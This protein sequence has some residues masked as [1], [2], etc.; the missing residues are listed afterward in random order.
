MVAGGDGYTCILFNSGNVKCVGEN[1]SG[2]LG[3]GTLVDRTTWVDTLGVSQAKAITAGGD[4]NCVLNT[5]DTIQCWGG[6]WGGQLANGDFAD[7]PNAVVAQKLNEDNPINLIWTSWSGSQLGGELFSP[8]PV[9]AY[10]DRDGNS[11]D[12][13]DTLSIALYTERSCT[14]PAPALQGTTSVTM[15]NG[16]A[17][18]SGIKSD[19]VGGFYVKTTS[20]AGG[21][22]HCDYVGLAGPGLQFTQY[23]TEAF[24]NQ[25]FAVLPKLKLMKADWSGVLTTPAYNVTLAAFS[26][27]TC[28][29]AATGVLS[30]DVNPATTSGG[31]VSF[32]NVR[33]SQAGDIFIKASAPGVS[34]TCFSMKIL[35]AP[36]SPYKLVI[37]RNPA[38]GV[39]GS[40]LVSD[41]QVS[42]RDSAG[43][44]MTSATHSITLSAYTDSQCTNAASGTLTA[45]SNPV[46]AVGGK[47]VFNSISYPQIGTIYVKATTGGLVA[48]CAGP[49]EVGGPIG[50]VSSIAWSN[51]YGTAYAGISAQNAPAVLLRDGL[52][53]TVTSATN[54]V[55][56][57]AYSD[58]CNTPVAP[59]SF[60][61][62]SPTT[63]AINGAAVFTGVKF[64]NPGYYGVRAEIGGIKS[65]CGWI[66]VKAGCD[67]TASVFA[68]GNG[69][70]SNPYLIST[71]SQLNQV[72]NYLN[73]NYRL[74]NSINLSGVSFAPIGSSASPFEGAFDGNSKQIQNWSYTD[75][76]TTS[77]VG[78]FGYLNWGSA[79]KNLA[80]T[81]ASVSAT[82]GEG[83]ILAGYNLGAVDNCQAAGT[84]NAKYSGGLV[85]RN[86]GLIRSSSSTATVTGMWV[87]GLCS[88][89]HGYVES[90]TA[91]GSV[92]STGGHA[93]GLAY[94]HTGGHIRNSSATGAVA[95]TGG[96]AGGLV[97]ESYG[98]VSASYATGTVNASTG[99]GLIGSSQSGTTQ[100]SYATG[101]VTAA[102]NNSAGFVGSV[103]N[104]KLFNNYATG[105]V[106]A[107]KQ[108]FSATLGGTSPVSTSNFWDTT[109]TGTTQSGS[110]T[111]KSTAQM[112]TQSTFTGWDFSNIWQISAGYPT[113]R[114]GAKNPP[115]LW[116]S[117]GSARAGRTTPFSL[118]LYSPDGLPVRASIVSGPTSGQLSA[119]TQDNVVYYT[120]QTGYAGG[121]DSFTFRAYDSSGQ[122]SLYDETF[123]IVILPDCDPGVSGFDGG[124]GQ[125]TDPYLIS[126]ITQLQQIRNNVACY[127][128]LTAN[129]DLS[130]VTFAPIGSDTVPFSGGLDGNNKTISNW[131]YSAAVDRVGFFAAT[132]YQSKV[133]N[134]VMTNVSVSGNAFVGA[135]VG[136]G[137]GD[138]SNIQVS[139]TVSGQ[140]YTGGIGGNLESNTLSNLRFS[141]TV[142]GT[143]SYVGGIA[144]ILQANSAERF[145]SSANVTGPSYVGGIAGL[146]YRG[147]SDCAS[148]G[149]VTA[150]SGTAGGAFGVISGSSGYTITRCFASGAVSGSTSGGLVG[151][152]SG[153][154]QTITDSFWD[155]QSTGKANTAGSGATGKTTAELKTQSTYTNWDFTT[156][157]SIS[158]GQYPT[159]R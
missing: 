49:I 105:S 97:G 87:G 130:G 159:L 101:A 60:H 94:Q 96:Y 3:D 53:N 89:Q 8:Q 13:A 115:T 63:N 62:D 92:T 125:L 86:Q 154:Q 11:V 76:A 23:P 30:M 116:A 142:T 98:L 17:T 80:F 145:Q 2:D 52:Q 29:T 25:A 64:D 108:G 38:L 18:F 139:G 78:F 65:I 104:S 44:L 146:N 67:P 110:G 81:G 58:F 99:G 111:G 109:T 155:T 31:Y 138:L 19:E 77:Q 16:V 151:S 34:S 33:Y 106:G 157:W 14:T 1:G 133:Q 136:F 90:S 51:F 12:I 88:L 126:T 117:S 112:Q 73:C 9:L 10:L 61:A 148:T 149:S 24:V 129:L 66:H 120:P 26:D 93:G 103:W 20:S 121:T 21:P 102:S 48:G 150:T 69:S 47:A 107:T 42:V 46:N 153:S 40:S 134:L 6:N 32:F 68:G 39:A 43:S 100:N 135:V 71:A 131:S 83:G 85:A 152:V 4:H 5:D 137:R 28:S 158:A 82:S 41:L 144:G 113:I 156:V 114:A 127:F 147:L 7:K 55:T 36:G 70:T 141:G 118:S 128:K 59:G 37:D 124:H 84:V 54:A 91:S 123:S 79:V 15:V 56:L 50:V 119:V 57:V 75:N 140:P 27:N 74:N 35:P 22:T 143:N 45:S 122:A 72:R 132:D 95:A